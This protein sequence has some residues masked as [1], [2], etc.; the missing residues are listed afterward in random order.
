MCKE[1]SIFE[2][3]GNCLPWK[4]TGWTLWI[5]GDGGCL[6][7]PVKDVGKWISQSNRSMRKESCWASPPSALAQNRLSCRT[8]LDYTIA[9]S[10]MTKKRSRSWTTVHGGTTYCSRH[11]VH[12]SWIFT[13]PHNVERRQKLPQPSD[14]TY[15]EENLLKDAI[16]FAKDHSQ[17]IAG[18]RG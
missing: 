8:V 14:F 5:P 4:G 3:W 2:Y 6:Q 1:K 12:W 16:A 11:N 17:N 13:A 15:P 7:L 10:T 9:S 18:T